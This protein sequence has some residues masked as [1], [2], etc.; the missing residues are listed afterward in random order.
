M[1]ISNPTIP[2]TT[3]IATTFGSSKLWLATTSAA[4]IFRWA[5]PSPKTDSSE[6]AAIGSRGPVSGVVRDNF[7]DT[8][9]P[10][11]DRVPPDPCNSTFSQ[12]DG[13]RG[14]PHL[15]MLRSRTP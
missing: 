14:R 4:A 15:E 2:T 1:R 12:L 6:L 11:D 5:V 7:R 13:G 3:T 8:F 10:V 9:L